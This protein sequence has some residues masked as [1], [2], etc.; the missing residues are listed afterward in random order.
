MLWRFFGMDGGRCGR[1]RKCRDLSAEFQQF[2]MQ[3]IVLLRAEASKLFELPAKLAL[4]PDCINSQRR[5]G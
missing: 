5:R 1:L 3:G 2:A 4:S